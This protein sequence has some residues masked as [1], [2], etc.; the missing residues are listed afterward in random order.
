[1]TGTTSSKTVPIL[2]VR[3]L[4]VDFLSDRDPFRAVDSVGFHVSRGETLCILG[5]SGSGKSVST[6]AIMGLID[7]PPGDIVAGRMIFDG[8]DLAT[9]TQEERRD[10]NGRKIAMIFQDPLA[11]LNPV[12]TIGRQIAEVFEAHGVAKGA[13]AKRR[14]VDLL[15]RVGIPDP[16]HRID[17]YPHQFSG[18]QRQRV[19][20]AMAIAL[21]PAVIIADE[22]TTALDVSVQA[23]ILELLRGLQAEYGMALVM[24]THDLEVAASMAD[25]V[26]VMKGGRIV[27]EGYARD[28]FTHPQHDYTQKLLSALPHASDADKGHRRSATSAGELLLKVEN[29]V[30]RYRSAPAC[31]ARRITLMPSTMSASRSRR[32]KPSASSASPV[33]ANR[34]SRASSCA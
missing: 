23:Q 32:A 3:G 18:G 24:I 20:I 33:P 22:P 25:R 5:E 10:L 16:E 14:V 8:R 4:T 11:H 7:T 17:Q 13:E 15:R 31:S 26:M 19:M 1:M 2:E 30:K 21:Q 34:A 27:E 6:S 9:M 29:V 12:H 28:V